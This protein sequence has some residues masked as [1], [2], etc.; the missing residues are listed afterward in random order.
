MI[1]LKTQSGSLKTIKADMIACI[2]FEDGAIFER[3]RKELGKLLGDLSPLE[4]SGFE[5]KDKE[6]L[7]LFPK[8]L[9]AKK[10]LIIGGGKVQDLTAEKLRRVSAAAVK[11]AE[12]NKVR[13]LAFMEPNDAAIEKAP[14]LTE[15]GWSFIFMS[16]YEGAALGSYRFDKYFTG[17]N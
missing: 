10:F 16:L 15:G 3:Q 4:H 5:G 1:K 13:T 7:I 8:G 17:T 2:V 14:A 11:A 9:R 6:S 12:K